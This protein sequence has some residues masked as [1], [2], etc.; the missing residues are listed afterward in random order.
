MTVQR[1]PL[2]PWQQTREE[3][4]IVSRSFIKPVEPSDLPSPVQLAIAIFSEAKWGADSQ[5]LAPVALGVFTRESASAEELSELVQ[6]NLQVIARSM[7]DADGL[8]DR[9]LLI[10]YAR[11]C[12]CGDKSADLKQPAARVRPFRAAG[13]F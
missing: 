1:L 2:G 8:R 13:L 5:W 6:H 3:R 4:K 7:K 11:L 10:A 9:A 12:G